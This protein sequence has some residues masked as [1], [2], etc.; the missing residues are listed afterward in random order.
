MTIAWDSLVNNDPG[1]RMIAGRTRTLHPIE[2]NA[3]PEAVT[4]IRSQ[5]SDAQLTMLDLTET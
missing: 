3:R 4:T 1:V 5:R 2:R